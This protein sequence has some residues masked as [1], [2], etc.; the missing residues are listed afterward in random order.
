MILA[1]LTTNIEPLP[2]NAAPATHTVVKGDSL[3]KIAVKYQLPFN[4]ILKANSH[5][6]NPNLIYPN[7]QINLPT[8]PQRV[9]EAKGI[10]EQVL[11]L[12]NVER[13]KA[14]V[15]PLQMD[16]E[17]QR[18]AR[19]KSCDMAE[20]NYFSHDSPTYGS[21]FDMMK[22]FGIKYK[23]A[24]E[25]IASGQKTA[26]SVMNSWLNSSGHRANILKGS[27]THIGVGYC[28]GGTMSPYWTQQ[29]ITK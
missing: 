21:P 16:W 18:V 25:N 27:F 14:G 9:T 7:Q 11:A 17:L 23:A 12:V 2:V 22:D 4:E 10:E 6:K 3:W 20:K 5:L 13:K 19:I 29:F 28:E 1:F 15:A 8:V 24:G 26:Q